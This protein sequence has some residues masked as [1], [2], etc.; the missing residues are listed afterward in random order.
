M[1]FEFV[2]GEAR[3]SLIMTSSTP[4][5]PPAHAIPSTSQTV[6]EAMRDLKSV[7]V[8]QLI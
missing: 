6:V 4:P 3:N 5:R 7:S 1:L 8:I 2:N